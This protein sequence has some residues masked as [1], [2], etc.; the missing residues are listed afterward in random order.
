MLRTGDG[1]AGETRAIA[2][3]TRGYG[4]ESN[5]GTVFRLRRGR[6][7]T[8]PNRSGSGSG[9]IAAF[10]GSDRLTTHDPTRGSPAPLSF[11][12]L[13][14]TLAARVRL[15][16]LELEGDRRLV[17]HDPAIVARF[18]VMPRTAQSLPHQGFRRWAST[19]PVS[20]SRRKP[21]TGPLT[22]SR[23][24]LSPAGDDEL[25][26]EDQ[27][28]KPPPVC[29]VRLGSRRATVA[30]LAVGHRSG[31]GVWGEALLV[32]GAAVAGLGELA[33]DPQ[34]SAVGGEHEHALLESAPGSHETTAP[35]VGSRLA[36]WWGTSP[37]AT[38]KWP[39]T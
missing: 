15:G 18:P 32:D 33:A 31:N 37:P 30:R 21:A 25:T 34:V 11:S 38:S 13:P 14:W 39:P 36:R 4:R 5:G 22:A 19:R 24:G 10:P 7:A 26:T 12:L 35:L 28:H 29:W 17:A 23:T 1:A 6:S 3:M 9:T 16:A 2:G 8:F 27:L 20:R